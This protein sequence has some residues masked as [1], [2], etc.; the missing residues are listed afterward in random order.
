MPETRKLRVFLCHASQDK[1]V[2]RELYQKLLAESWIDPWLDEDKLLPGQD[3]DM[4]IKKAM[5]A[6]DAVIVCL[7]NNSIT[8]AGYVQKELRA[9]LDKAL[10]KPEGVIF[11]VPLRLDD[12]SVPI[13]LKNWH[14]VNYFEAGGYPKLLRSFQTCASQIGLIAFSG[15]QGQL[16]GIEFVKIPAGKFTIGS[17]EENKLAFQYEKPQHILEIPYHYLIARFEVTNAQFNFYIEQTKAKSKSSTKKWRTNP[18]MPVVNVT[19][20][21]AIRFCQWM[22][23]SYHQHEHPDYVFRLP[24]EAEW[25]KAARG[26]DG[27]E[28]P[29]G[30]QFT[31]GKHPE[32]I[33]CN[34]QKS[35][36]G[37]PTPVEAYIPKGYSFYRVA[38]MVGN[39]WEWT[40]NLLKPYPY[41]SQ[42]GRENPKTPGE[43]VIRGGSF[44]KTIRSVRIACRS[45]LNPGFYLPSVSFRVVFAPPIHIR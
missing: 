32:D 19:W 44:D 8:K 36:V 4:E 34:C 28:W 37:K 5:E 1:P 11:V 43:R 15:M 45:R 14:W 2:V 17:R 39:V 31:F 38:D 12:C 10:E 13:S 24:T 6:A 41:D 25:E 7:S 16:G 29:W 23:D 27:R 35:K 40:Q 9:I 20:Y 33:P 30:N 42:D 3:W 18:D 22:T 26:D 21:E